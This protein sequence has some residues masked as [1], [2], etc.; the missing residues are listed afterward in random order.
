MNTRGSVVED[1]LWLVRKTNQGLEYVKAV[2]Y[3]ATNFNID[4][5]GKT[6]EG[7]VLRKHDGKWEDKKCDEL[8]GALCE[9]LPGKQR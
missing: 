9:F 8:N 3:N 5:E 6:G 1:G 7:C 4:S 2:G